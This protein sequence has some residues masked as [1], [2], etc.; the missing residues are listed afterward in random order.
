[1]AAQQ[2]QQQQQQQQHSLD[3]LLTACLSFDNQVCAVR[4]LAP[5]LDARTPQAA[6]Q[7]PPPRCA[8]RLL[9]QLCALS[10]RPALCTPQ[11]I[12]P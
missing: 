4:L 11:S 6:A 2:Q 10:H 5:L 1:M 3:T 7:P 8:M 12:T 9:L